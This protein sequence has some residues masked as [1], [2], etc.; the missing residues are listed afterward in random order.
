MFKFTNI[1]F[2]LQ[3]SISLSVLPAL[4]LNDGIIH[5]D[6]VEGP[7]D[8]EHFEDFIIG[9]LENMNPFPAPNSVI[10][11][12]NCRIHK[13]PAIL[14]HITAWY[15]VPQRNSCS[16]FHTIVDAQLQQDAI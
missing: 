11:M 4:T 14:E 13:N 9:L 12:D 8:S 3:P 1:Y 6:V 16:I 15:A 5:C 7:F 10:V 2:Y